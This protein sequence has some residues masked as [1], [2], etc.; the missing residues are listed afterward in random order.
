VFDLPVLAANAQE[1]AAHD[2]VLK[3]LDKASGGKT[4]WRGRMF[5]VAASVA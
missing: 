2:D 3:Q 4:V 1:L 5:D